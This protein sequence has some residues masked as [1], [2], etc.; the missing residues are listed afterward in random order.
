ML[1]SPDPATLPCESTGSGSGPVLVAIHGWS[2]SGRWLLD[3]LPTALLVGRRALAPDLRGHGRSPDGGSFTLDALAGD[4]VAALDARGVERAVMLGWSLGA[5]VALAAVPRLSGRVAGLALVSATARFTE[6]DDWPH[7]LPRAHAGRARPAGRARSGARDRAVPRRHV[8]RRRARRSGR[9]A[10]HRAPGGGPAG[11]DDGPPRRPRGARRHGPA[12]YARGDRRALARRARRGRPDL[13]RARAARSRRRCRPRGSPSRPGRA[14]R[15]SSRAPTRSSARSRHSSP[16]AP[17]PR[18]QA[19]RARRVLPLRQRVRRAPRSSAPCRTAPR[20][21]RG[22]RPDARRVLD[23]GAGTGALLARLVAAR[24]GLS[25]AAIDLAP[26]M[27]PRRAAPLRRARHR[28]GRRGA[29]VSATPFDLV[30]T[31]STLQWSRASRPRSRRRRRVPRAGGVRAVRGA[32]AVR[33]CARPGT[34]RPARAPQTHRSPLAELAAGLARPLLRGD[35]ARRGAVERHPTRA[36][37]RAL[38]GGRGRLERSSILGSLGG[39][40]ATLEAIRVTMS[41]TRPGG[42]RDGPGWTRIA[43]TPTPPWPRA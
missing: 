30:V 27:A 22:R 39:R 41:A 11:K 42:V 31:T 35:D 4:V 28:R 25:A 1:P 34:R 16:H 20:A 24:P 6:G 38:E 10:R 3:A 8:P 19:P 29:A 17:E 14:T 32:P 26:E 5:Q 37:L 36:A 23:V 2:L 15:P 9:G 18:R 13:P 43:L 40:R 21:P 33:A 7:G 12:R